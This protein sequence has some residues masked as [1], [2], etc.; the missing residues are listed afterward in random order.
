MRKLKLELFNC[1]SSWGLW[2][3]VCLPG[4]NSQNI[5]LLFYFYFFQ[6]WRGFEFG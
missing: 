3:R 5:C 1:S 6:H 4:Y 2:K